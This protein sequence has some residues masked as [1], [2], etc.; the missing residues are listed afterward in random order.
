MGL[1]EYIF[2]KRLISI[3]KKDEEFL[4]LAQKV[5]KNR[6]EIINKVREMKA[7]GEEIPARYKAYLGEEFIKKIK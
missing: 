7:R 5:D 6:I 4:K 2:G 1:I 3:L